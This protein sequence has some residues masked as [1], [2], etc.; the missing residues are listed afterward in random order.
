MKVK[1]T[2]IVCVLD[3]KKFNFLKRIDED[4][5]EGQFIINTENVTLCSLRA[6]NVYTE[7]IDLKYLKKAQFYLK[8]LL[9]KSRK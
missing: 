6:S 9:L 1:G 8:V 5:Y 2:S 3:G 7:F 4:I